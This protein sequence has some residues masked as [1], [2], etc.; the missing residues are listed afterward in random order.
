MQKV[1]TFYFIILI[2]F[3]A[4]CAFPGVY[5]IDVQQ[6]NIV[7]EEALNQLQVGMNRKQVHFVLGSP[8]IESTFTPEYEAYLYTIQVAGGE[9][10]RQNIVLFYNN[11]ILGKLEKRELLSAQLANPAEARKTRPDYQENL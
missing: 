4:G 9:V 7:D 2:C 3:L 10:H 6:G 1:A 8:V 5:I 11:D